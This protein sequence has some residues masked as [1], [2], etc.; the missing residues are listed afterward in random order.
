MTHSCISPEPSAAAQL[1]RSTA[2]LT[3]PESRMG[4]Q[5]IFVMAALCKGEN[6]G[7]KSK[8]FDSHFGE[9]ENRIVQLENRVTKRERGT[10]HWV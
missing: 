2:L 7:Y 8:A 1:S 6:Q 5:K 9:A 3:S 10:E 4:S